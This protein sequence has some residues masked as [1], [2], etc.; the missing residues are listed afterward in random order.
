MENLRQHDIL[1]NIYWRD[2]SLDVTNESLDKIIN[3]WVVLLCFQFLICYWL[4]RK[5]IYSQMFG[6]RNMF[7]RKVE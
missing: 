1:I 7:D 4:L 5:S 3:I 6:S 2:T